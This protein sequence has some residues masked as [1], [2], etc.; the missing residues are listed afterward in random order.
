MAKTDDEELTFGQAVQFDPQYAQIQRKKLLAKALQDRVLGRKVDDIKRHPL[1][2]VAD[3]M[4]ARKGKK[5][6]EASQAEEAALYQ[7][8][9]QA[10]QAGQ[11]EVI[12]AMESGD[13]QAIQRALVK[14]MAS[15]YPGVSKFAGGLSKTR[16]EQ[17]KNAITPLA[18]RLDP[19]SV[20]GAAN[21]ADLSSVRPSTPL[22]PPRL[23]SG[24]DGA[25]KPRSW[26]ES[27]NIKGEWHGTPLSDP[28]QINNN[29]AMQ[30]GFK[31]LEKQGEFYAAG[32]EGFKAAQASQMKL[33]QTADLLR[34]LEKNPAMGAG[35]NAFQVA[36]SW[37]E[38]LGGKPVELTGDTTAMKQQLQQYVLTALGGKLGNQ[39]SDADRKFMMEAIGE[40]DT[41]PAAL[42]RVLLIG[43]KNE[44][45]QLST[46]S[47]QA[48]ALENTP[49][50]KNAGVQFPGYMFGTPRAGENPGPELPAQDA[51]DLGALLMNRLPP[52]RGL[53]PGSSAP[54]QRPSRVRPK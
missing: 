9:Q 3:F 12:A 42:R 15:R 53:G 41:N 1:A 37:L 16:D 31:T 6:L 2:W 47:E 34:Q 25:G 14:A 29:M 50:M 43:L 8:H 39:I 26:L 48:I 19:Q 24:V 21:R 51:D 5:Q 13:P 18:D 27:Q 44:M 52:L 7:R 11:Q 35:A 23:A 10:E 54:V 49:A 22:A 28:T 20:L 30:P 17:F 36:R 38:T 45:M 40:L 4:T 46:L 33:N 32:G